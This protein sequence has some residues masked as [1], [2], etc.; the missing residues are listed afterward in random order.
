[1]STTIFTHLHSQLLPHHL[2]GG[3]SSIH[4][5][6][7]W[8]NT[9][10]PPTQRAF[11]TLLKHFEQTG[12][13]IPATTSLAAIDSLSTQLGKQLKGFN[14]GIGTNTSLSNQWSNTSHL[15]HSESFIA[16]STPKH[17]KFGTTMF[18]LSFQAMDSAD[19]IESAKH[20]PDINNKQQ[21]TSVQA[22]AD[23]IG[24]IEIDE[25]IDFNDL[26]TWVMN[27]NNGMMIKNNS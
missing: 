19:N 8:G 17:G 21:E 4:S 5:P 11:P 12:N 9:N 27:V 2:T 6:A 18:Y 24:G 25:D 16:S 13:P 14:S 15:N 26:S 3:T 7:K 1:M 10:T 20:L 22:L 23:L